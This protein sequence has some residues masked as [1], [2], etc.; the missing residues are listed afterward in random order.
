MA[1]LKMTLAAIALSMTVAPAHADSWT[2]DPAL[3]KVSF[4][5][6]KNDY[7]GENHSFGSVSGTVSTQGD[8]ALQLG[9]ESVSTNIDI[10]DERMIEHVFKTAAVATVTAQVDMAE[11][12]GMAIGEGR[13]IETYGTLE[14]IGTNTD[15]DAKL[16]VIRLT[17]DKVL[18]TTD[19]M[20]MLSTEDTGLDTGIDILQEL[21]GLDSITRV[22]PVTMRLVFNADKTNS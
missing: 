9:L 13:E 6:I 7:F 10:R 20:I 19:G 12:E 16:F 3:S 4:A 15:L 21:A 22:S 17:E 1:T 11:F 2:L 14:L 5:S 8:V 18:V